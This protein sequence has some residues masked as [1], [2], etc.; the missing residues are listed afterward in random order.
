MKTLIANWKANPKTLE[1]AKILFEAENKPGVIICPPAAFLAE[2]HA[3]GA[4]DCELD[5]DV[6]HCLV[7]HSDR[8]KAGDTDEIVNQKLLAVLAAGLTPVLLIETVDQLRKALVDV[9]EE[10]LDKILYVYEPVWA[11]S[12]NPNARPVT[13]EYVLSAV[14]EMQSFLHAT[15]PFLYG[16]SVNSKN[17]ADFLKYPEI[18]G[19]IVGAASLN[20]EE[21]AKMIEITGKLS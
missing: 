18:S 14:R 19:A 10:D 12:T 3:N 20:A 17:L 9:R 16:G 2:L 1:E 13:P 7:G 8:R 11:I 21:F 15:R 5:K 4:Q 6:T